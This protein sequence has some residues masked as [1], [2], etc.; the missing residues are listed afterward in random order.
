MPLNFQTPFPVQAVVFDAVGTV[1][2]PAPSVADAYRDAI[3][4][5]FGVRINLQHIRDTTRT[6][7]QQRSATPDLKT[8]EA[9]ERDFWAQLVHQLCPVN[10]PAKATACFEDLFDHFA[11]PSSWECFPEV[12]S[13]VP[14]LQA[15]EL[16]LA[17]AS[18][19]DRR[20]NTVC[21]GLP[22]LKEI[23]HRFISSVVGCRKPAPEFF[24]AVCSG[25]QVQP[26]NV[27]FVGDDLINDVQGALQA[28]MQA[29]WVA[30]QANTE[31]PPKHCHVLSTL[32]DLLSQPADVPSSSRH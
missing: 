28:G 21:D 3:E 13:V 9:A 31:A 27:L 26:Q 1:M 19:F 4:R 29:A 5:H 30:R 24:S 22:P 11:R 6:A 23:S 20:L 8:D 2:Y 16:G 10:D 7:L 32:T 25:L 14:Q 18:N 12:R 15:A 17:I